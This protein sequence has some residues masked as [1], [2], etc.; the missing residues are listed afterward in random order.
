MG[1]EI[2]DIRFTKTD[3]SKF[4]HRLRQETELLSQYFHEQRFSADPY[5]CGFEL[6]AWIVDQNYHP[7]PVNQQFLQK[8]PNPLVSP[9]LAAF[10]V[11][12]NY[13][14]LTLGGDCLQKSFDEMQHLWKLGTQ[15][16]EQLQCHLAMIGILPTVSKD[17]LTMAN[18]SAMKRYQALNEQVLRLREGKPLQ[19]DIHGIEVLRASHNDVMLESAT[20]SFQIHLQVPPDLAVRA[21]NASIILSAPMLAISANSPFFLGKNLWCETRI[22]LFEQAV[23]VGGFGGA[24][25]GPLRRVTFGS[26]YARESI[27]EIFAENLAHYPILLPTLIDDPL[28]QFSNLRLHNGTLWRWNRPLIGIENGKHHVRIEHRVVPAGPSIVDAI[29][30]AALYYGLVKY[31]SYSEI[32]PEVQLPFE[33]ARDNFYHA[34]QHGMDSALTWVDGKKYKFQALML[35]TLLPQAHSGLTQ[36]GIHAAHIKRYL[37]IIEARAHNNCNGAAWQRAFVAKYGSDMCALTAAYL[38]RQNSGEPVHDWTL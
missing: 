28:E 18:I 10:N 38:E 17:D 9:E 24:A 12:F 36:L 25:H 32:A 19:V 6:E 16:A 5:T 37:G 22:P 8:F 21:Y 27:L 31:Y 30:N 15:T 13:T 7:S 34:A 11:E 33:I 1:Q 35:D 26:G 23:A 4:H 14:P 2:A 3:F 29:A 20:T